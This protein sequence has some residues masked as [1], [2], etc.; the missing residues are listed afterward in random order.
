MT[1][2]LPMTE[3]VAA[4]DDP[5]ACPVWDR[6]GWIVE[7]SG[8]MKNSRVSWEKDESEGADV[9]DHPFRLVEQFRDPAR[10]RL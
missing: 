5:S 2:T 3:A 1:K 8:V 10:E 7:V 6:I 9:D 4:T